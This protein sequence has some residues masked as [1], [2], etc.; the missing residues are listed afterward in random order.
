M[1][2]SDP[3]TQDE[4]DRICKVLETLAKKHTIETPYGEAEVM[5]Y[6]L[7]AELLQMLFAENKELKARLNSDD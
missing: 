7:A 4:I 2:N 1:S 6:G 3:I 5:T